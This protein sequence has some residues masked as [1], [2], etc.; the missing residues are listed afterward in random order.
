MPEAVWFPT[1]VGVGLFMLGTV[2]DS[3][4][5]ALLAF[6]SMVASRAILEILYR[7]MFGAARLEAR[8]AWTAFG[9]QIVVWL[10]IWGWHAQRVAET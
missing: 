4:S 8:T 5:A 1:Y 2:S 7:L 3:V 10:L 6:A 9:M